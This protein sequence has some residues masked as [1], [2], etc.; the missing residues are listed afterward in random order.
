[1]GNIGRGRDKYNIIKRIIYYNK[2]KEKFRMNNM[3]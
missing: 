1:M 3:L 2:M